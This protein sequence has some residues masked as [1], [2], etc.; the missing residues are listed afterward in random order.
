[1]HELSKSGID[2]LTNQTY[3]FQCHRCKKIIEET[4][5]TVFMLSVFTAQVEDHFKLV[6][7]ETD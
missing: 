7:G 3:I 4:G 6:H 2:K 1:M 5:K